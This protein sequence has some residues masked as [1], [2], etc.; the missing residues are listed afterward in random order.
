MENC[1]TCY[2]GDV[3]S[4]QRTLRLA[5]MVVG[6]HSDVVVAVVVAA[7]AGGGCLL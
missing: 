1:L 4:I 3:Q 5:R 2:A 6:H 7:V